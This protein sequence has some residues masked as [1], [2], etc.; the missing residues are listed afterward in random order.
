MTKEKRPFIHLFKV[1]SNTYLYDVNTDKILKIP[2]KVYES[3]HNEKFNDSATIEFL[4]NLKKKGF[5]KTSRVQETEHPETP[6]LQSYLDSKVT[7]IV[8]QVTQNCNLRCDYC[9]Y[10][11]SYHNRVHSNKRMSFELA[12]KGIDFLAV[13]SADCEML[14][15]GFYGG[16]PLLE[17]ELIKECMEYA[18]IRCKGKK[19]YYNLTT[20]GTLVTKEMIETFQKYDVHLMVSLD[21]PKKIHDASRKGSSNQGSYDRLI[22]NLEMVKNEV[23]EF[24]DKNIIFNTVL[25]PERGYSCVVDFITGNELL[26]NKQ[27]LMSIITPINSKEKKELSEQF[28]VEERYEY[29]LM[30]LSKIGEFSTERLSPFGKMASIRFSEMRFQK[31]L[32]SSGELPQKHHHPGPCIPGSFRLF[33]NA[34][35]NFFPCERVCETTDYTNIGNIYD[36]IDIEKAKNIL[37]VEKYTEKYCHECWAYNYCYMCIA[38]IDSTY[39]TLEAAVLSKCASIKQNIEESFKDYCVLRAYNIT[40]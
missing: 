38:D 23:P 34:D 31:N 32:K 19:I 20:N 9:V 15:I 22:K 11:G 8:L 29:F 17:F 36:G 16:E 7:S 24:F 6:Y 4:E 37:N 21:G 10:S 33:M 5:L 25:N 35:G 13:H 28:I 18:A 2:E 40:Y 30:L 26:K 1:G 12:K 14:H 27:F 3:L 39:E